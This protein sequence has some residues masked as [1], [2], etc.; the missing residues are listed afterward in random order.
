MIIWIKKYKLYIKED[1]NFATNIISGKM[2]II[3][4]KFRPNRTLPAYSK[5]T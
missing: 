2:S 1:G 4:M 5:D 3:L